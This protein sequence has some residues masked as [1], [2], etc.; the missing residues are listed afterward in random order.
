ML[1]LHLTNGDHAASALAR[2]GLPGDI[3][4]W[5]DLLHD[6]PV[7]SDRDRVAF[8]RA[9][10]EFLSSRGWMSQSALIAD[11][12]ERDARL[13]EVGAG[14]EVVLWFEPDLYDQLQ[15]LQVLARLA[16]R[17]AHTRPALTIA[18]A[19]C[20][21][22]PLA[23]EKFAPLYRNRRPMQ[24]SDLA[25]AA[26]AWEAFT[27]ATPDALLA[28]TDRLDLEV[29]ARAYAYDDA[30]RLPHLVAALRR[31]LEEYPDT[32]AGLSRSERQLCEALAPGTIT[33]AKL[34]AAQQTAESWVWLGD[35]SFAWY[36]QRLS[37][38]A[39]P[40][41][42]HTNGSRVIAPLREADGKAFWERPVQL[43]P[44]GHDVVRDRADHVRL[45]GI[46][47]WIGGVQCNVSRHWRWDPHRHALVICGA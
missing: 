18:P 9:R 14:D 10:G 40:L 12:E 22:G 11:F 8:R 26:S 41:V 20:Y 29:K 32:K 27:A 13:D 6:G 7:P 39:H 36:V 28:I 46:D 24:D 47:R 33:L 38:C 45:N 44:L 35:W 4:S 19:D 2:S 1:T 25:I 31:Q 15:L 30:E 34:F 16:G 21:L 3:L 5:R 37:D 23:P 43:T 42:V 17:P